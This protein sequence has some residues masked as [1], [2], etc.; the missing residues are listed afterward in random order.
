MAGAGVQRSGASKSSS[1]ARG[2]LPLK[3][4]NNVAC[5]KNIAFK[6]PRYARQLG[7]AKVVAE[8]GNSPSLDSHFDA[9]VCCP[10]NNL[11]PQFLSINYHAAA[12]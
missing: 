3:F 5:S 2:E 12:I 4:R 6:H 11:H 8:I 10:A 9:R 7:L 1:P